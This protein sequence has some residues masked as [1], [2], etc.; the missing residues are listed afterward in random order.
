ML[1]I[2][3]Y[4]RKN[5]KL[6]LNVPQD[7]LFLLASL[8]KGL[9]DDKFKRFG[10]IY[11]KP[12]S[13]A[14]RTMSYREYMHMKMKFM[15]YRSLRFHS[16]IAGKLQ[17]PANDLACS[18]QRNRA[19]KAFQ[20]FLSSKITKDDLKRRGIL[21]EDKKRWVLFK[22]VWRIDYVQHC[23]SGHYGFSWDVDNSIDASYDL[24]DKELK[25]FRLLLIGGYIRLYSVR[26]DT[27]PNEV[28]ILIDEIYGN[29]EVKLNILARPSLDELKKN[30][31]LKMS[32][33]KNISPA[34]T[35]IRRP[36]C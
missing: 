21:F 13:W 16:K 18:I 30:G 35:W 6:T 29:I 9:V 14:W 31:V 15:A 32:H 23:Y 19:K 12:N 24:S 20:H 34:L 10:K 7:I 2:E 22:S 5:I 4:I 26:R 1:L 33:G 17:P 28:I 11:C 3:G 8:T 25:Y 36:E 27:F